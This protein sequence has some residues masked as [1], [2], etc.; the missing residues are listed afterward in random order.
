MILKYGS[1]NLLWL[2]MT[3]MVP[4]G[5]VSFSLPFMPHKQTLKVTDIIGLIVVLSGLVAYRFA[6]KLWKRMAPT[7]LRITK[8]CRD[9]FNRSTGRAVSPSIQP[10]LGAGTQLAPDSPLIFGKPMFD[11][12]RECCY[13]HGSAPAKLSK[14]TAPST[15][16]SNASAAR[17][18]CGM[19]PR[20]VRL[21][22]KMPAILR[23]APLGL[24]PST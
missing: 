14:I 10:L 15:P 1:S 20:M 22:L 21:P 11:G 17:S 18:G 7:C 5:N 4:L 19:S 13:G 23:A 16:P 8:P 12:M 2:A 6:G 24:Q 9:C 3:V